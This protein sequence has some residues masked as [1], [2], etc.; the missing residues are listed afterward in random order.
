M[1]DQQLTADFIGLIRL[2]RNLHLKLTTIILTK[3]V[4]VHST[5]KLG[6][7]KDFADEIQKLLEEKSREVQTLE[8]VIKEIEELEEEIETLLKN[9]A[10]SQ[11]Q[12]KQLLDKVLRF[13]GRIRGDA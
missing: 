2:R 1:T 8:L 13:A 12:V 3:D 9:D 11:E 10:R 6:K 4:F 5:A 7:I